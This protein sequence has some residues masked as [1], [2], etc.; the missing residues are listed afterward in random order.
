[1]ELIHALGIALA[2]GIAVLRVSSRTFRTKPEE[3][4]RSNMISFA[5]WEFSCFGVIEVKY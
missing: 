4:T 3:L 2:S 5:Y 1:M